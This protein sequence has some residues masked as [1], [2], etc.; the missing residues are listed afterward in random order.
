VAPDPTGWPTLFDKVYR[1]S[2]E[3]QGFSRDELKSITVPVLI[4][5][6]DHGFVPVEYS[7]EMSRLIPNA[8]LA[9]IP[10]ASHYVL[11]VD[12]EKFLPIVAAFLD[13]P[14]STLP[15]ATPKTG[16]HPGVTR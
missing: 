1:K 7:L 3:W 6:G 16:Y 11:N 5:S 9:V 10:G 13:E 2:M 15:F 8:Q 14:I 4:A 12:P